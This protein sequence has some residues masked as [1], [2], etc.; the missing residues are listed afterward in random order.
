MIS[1]LNNQQVKNIKMLQKRGKVRKKQNAFVIEGMKMFEESRLEGNLIKS[2]FSEEFYN[3]KWKE[4][5]TYFNDLSYEVIKDSIFNELAST[6]TPQGVL[7][8]VEK[9][10]YDINK[11]IKD[12]ASSLLLLENI[13]DPGNLGTMVRTA[14]GAGFTGIIL[15]KDCVDMLNPKVVRSTMGSIYRVPFVY[16][17]DF[18]GALK[19][20]KNNNIPIYGAYL[21]GAIDYDKLEYSAKC[22]V[23]IGNESKGLKESTAGI[24]DHLIKIPMKGQVESLNAAIAAAIIMFEISSRRR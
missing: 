8:V 11:I 19:D 16:V 10:K 13:Q 24:V 18:E 14:E 17:D 5:E 21:E 9:P 23:L 2:Y 1:S 6:Q 20:I 22:G 12:P 15:S 3:V 4:D 7:A